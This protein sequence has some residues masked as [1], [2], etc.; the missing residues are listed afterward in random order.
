MKKKLL[1]IDANHLMHRAYW[2]IQRSLSTSKGEQTNAVFGVCSMLLTMIQREKP[3]AIV[4]CFDEGKET[5]RHK[6]HEEYKA[7]RQE[8]PDD[9]YTQIP[10]IHQCMAAFSI[11]T[12]S[13]PTYEADD[14]IGTIAVRGAKEGWEVIIVTGDRD[15]FQ[16]ADH[17][18]K[19]AVPHKGYAEP[20]YLD[21]KGVEAKLGVRPDQVADYKG[22][23]GD[24]S[25]NLKGVKGIGPK[26]AAT[27]LQKYGTIESLYEHI[28][29]VKESNRLKLE[30]DR[31]SAFFCKKMATL[32]TDI[33]V[34]IDFATL[35]GQKPELKQ[36]ESFF[37]ELEFLTLRTRLRKLFQNEAFT[38]EYFSGE[39][40]IDLEEPASA[41]DSAGKEGRMTE[42]Q[43]PL[44][45]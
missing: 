9:F 16:M 13:D 29:E 39:F 7:G 26:S 36:V 34:T 3:D 22:L 21:A 15:L 44:L 37:S 10:R 14:L 31:E 11:P 30:A 41:E 43:L 4:A 28:A 38:R 32:V 27:L 2:A 23:V 19:I 20:E 17:S 12:Y 35:T 25:D 40:V 45:D 33:P 18:I 5:Y 8:T 1:L 24:A 42:A 6:L